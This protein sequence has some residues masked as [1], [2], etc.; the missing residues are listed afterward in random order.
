MPETLR[1]DV[2]ETELCWYVRVINADGSSSSCR[3][4]FKKPV[5]RDDVRYHP[6]VK[7]WVEGRHIDEIY[8]G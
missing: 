2:W 5:T 7:N 6:E 8:A 1:P 4:T 3:F